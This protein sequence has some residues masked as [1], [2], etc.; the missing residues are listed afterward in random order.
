[1][2]QFFLDADILDT[3]SWT[4]WTVW[5][6]TFWTLWTQYILSNMN[7]DILNSL[8]T[9][10]TMH[11]MDPDTLDVIGIG[12]MYI[13]DTKNVVRMPMDI[14]NMTSYEPRLFNCDIL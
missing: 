10:Y 7:T 11:T 8:D 14:L 5:T 13:V 1:M 12:F 3:H 2:I 4:L 6:R 9:L